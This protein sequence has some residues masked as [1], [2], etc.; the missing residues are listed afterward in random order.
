MAE[1][2]NVARVTLSQTPSPQISEKIL[3]F[4][5]ARGCSSA[6]TVIDENLIGGIIIQIGDLIFD[7]SVRGRLQNIRQSL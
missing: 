2:S 3:A 6:E 4:V 1:R 5:H 7:G